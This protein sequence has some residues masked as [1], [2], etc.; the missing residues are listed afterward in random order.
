MRS[1]RVNKIRDMKGELTEQMKAE[2]NQRFN[3]YG[4]YIELVKVMNVII[5]RDLRAA[6]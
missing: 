1:I 4:V 6:L 5:P 3:S 2:L